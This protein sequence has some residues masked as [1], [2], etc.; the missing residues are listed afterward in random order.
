MTWH[1]RRICWD[2]FDRGWTADDVVERLKYCRKQ[3]E[4]A[5][6]DYV[7]GGTDH[8]EHGVED[9]DELDQTDVR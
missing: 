6:R 1:V 5:Y 7:D 3:V 4:E 9:L 2:R 8:A